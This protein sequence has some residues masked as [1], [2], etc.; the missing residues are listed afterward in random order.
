M[1]PT[2]R[3]GVALNYRSFTNDTL[4]YYFVTQ[5]GRLRWDVQLYIRIST[6]RL[7]EHDRG[8]KGNNGLNAA[9][10]MH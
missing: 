2:R 10:L 8:S 5:Y 9:Y 4:R 1:S 3:H 7:P 6:S